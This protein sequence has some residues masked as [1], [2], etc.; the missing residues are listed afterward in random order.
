MRGS[1]NRQGPNAVSFRAAL[2]FSATVQRHL[3]SKFFYAHLAKIYTK[4]GNSTQ[5]LFSP[6]LLSHRR[7]K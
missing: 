7:M 3:E 1:C 2:N 4:C 5:V 6:V